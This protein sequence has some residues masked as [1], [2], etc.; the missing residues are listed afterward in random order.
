M[1]L[2]W[3]L[4]RMQFLFDPPDPLNWLGSPYSELNKLSSSK[5]NNAFMACSRRGSALVFRTTHTTFSRSPT[6]MTNG[7]PYSGRSS[8]FLRRLRMSDDFTGG[9]LNDGLPF[10]LDWHLKPLV[11]LFAFLCESDDS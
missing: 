2:P 7:I 4:L 6:G 1:R 5:K 9:F 3:G 8:S 10:R 11:N